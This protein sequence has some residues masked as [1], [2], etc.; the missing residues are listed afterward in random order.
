MTDKL[1]P[2]QRRK[3]MQAIKGKNTSLEKMLGAALWKKGLRYRKND[4][5]VFG[6]PDFVFKRKKVAVFTDSEF[7]HGKDW[8]SRKHTIKTNRDFWITK[9]EANIRRDILVNI[10]LQ[11]MGW[12][13]IRFWGKE[14]KEETERCVS[15]VYNA[16]KKPKDQLFGLAAEKAAV[17]RKKNRY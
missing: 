12:E 7:W 14:V 10:T 1:S 3:N 4:R 11:E 6:T 17:Y 5:S 9:I 16:V 8:G 2:A 13:V 15:A